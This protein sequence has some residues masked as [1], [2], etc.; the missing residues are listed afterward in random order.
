[1]HSIIDLIILLLALTIIINP[2]FKII[3]VVEKLKFSPSIQL[4]FFLY[5]IFKLLIKIIL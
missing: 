3:I 4:I 2:F 5:T 1:M